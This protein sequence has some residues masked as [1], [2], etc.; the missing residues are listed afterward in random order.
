MS[1][2]L[3][4]PYTS[5]LSLEGLKAMALY[6]EKIY[7]INP[8]HARIGDS[9][10]PN[11]A[12]MSILEDRGVVKYIPPAELLYTYESTIAEAIKE[13]LADPRF[14]SICRSAES[15]YWVIYE[16]KIPRKLRSTME[17]QSMKIHKEF[18]LPK[19]TELHGERSMLLPI[20]L[21]ESIMINH[22]LCATDKFSLTPITDDNLHHELLTLKLRASRSKFPK[23]LLVDYGFV[24]DIKID[25]AAFDVLSESVPMLYRA[26]MIDIL[27][28]RDKN[29]EALNRF[30]TEMGRVI[31]DVEN[32]FWDEDFYK[33][34]IDM[35]DTKVRP[36]LQDLRDSVETTKERFARIIKRGAALAPLPIVATLL[37]G[38]DPMLA[39]LASAGALVV[40]EYL[41]SAKKERRIHKNSMA[42]LFDAQ[43]RFS[44][45]QKSADS[46]S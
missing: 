24:K 13:D 18:H 22:A 9:N 26:S 6:F 14:R 4:Y 40:E 21:G 41:E 8:F 45:L 7:I 31:T 27:E 16:S 10:R 29:K 34:V 15:K 42:F 46:S 17:K 28:F 35:I 11:N 20:D 5:V 37:P 43:K 33:R 30:K 36:S 23:K 39:I 25:L 1:E 2:A 12:E 44:G 3:Y 32:N 19:K 38:C